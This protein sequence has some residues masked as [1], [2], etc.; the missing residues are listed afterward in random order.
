MHVWACVLL[1]KGREAQNNGAMVLTK[2]FLGKA[3]WT[4]QGNVQKSSWSVI[5]LLSWQN[6]LELRN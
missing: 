6:L 1:P 2:T 5:M 3:S 4:K